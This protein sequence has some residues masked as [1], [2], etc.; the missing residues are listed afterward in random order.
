MA[1]KRKSAEQTANDAKRAELAAKMA[2]H[3]YEPVVGGKN[4]KMDVGQIIEGKLMTLPYKAGLSQA[5]DIELDTGD[6][7]KEVVTYWAQTILANLLK[8]L[9]PGDNVYIECIGEIGTANG[10]AKDF[11]VAKKGR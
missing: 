3:G 6:G 8:R 5:F 9:K 4:L 10:D 2:E 11:F 1:S 7:G